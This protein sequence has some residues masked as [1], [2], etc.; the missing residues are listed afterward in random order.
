MSGE[1][2]LQRSIEGNHKERLESQVRELKE[3]VRTVVAKGER[4]YK[5]LALEKAEAEA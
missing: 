1:L 3:E 5:Q 2:N 4:E